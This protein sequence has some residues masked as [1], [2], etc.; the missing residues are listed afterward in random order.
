MGFVKNKNE[1]I[2]YNL[3]YILEVALVDEKNVL[4]LLIIPLNNVL[5]FM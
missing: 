2:L 5:V 3:S 1:L 4:L